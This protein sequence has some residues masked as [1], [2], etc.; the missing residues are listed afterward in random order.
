MSA[1]RAR[2]WAASP[3]ARVAT[4]YFLLALDNAPDREK[5]RAHL[6][7]RRRRRQLT[8]DDAA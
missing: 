8:E 5:G 3:A 2:A 7:P 6:P 4:A 1:S